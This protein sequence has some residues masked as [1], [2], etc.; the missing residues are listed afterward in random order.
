MRPPATVTYE[1]PAD[2]KSPQT[3]G[4]E[5]FHQ[6]ATRLSRAEGRQP[7]ATIIGYNPAPSQPVHRR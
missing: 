4:A 7:A 6:W 3:V 1:D 5:Q 2:P